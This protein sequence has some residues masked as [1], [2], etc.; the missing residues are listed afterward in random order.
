MGDVL[1]LIH[2]LMKIALV[3]VVMV[4]VATAP[5]RASATGHER[6]TSWV[7]AVMCDQDDEPSRSRRMLD[8]GDDRW[9][10]AEDASPI[11]NVDG[12]PMAGDLDIRGNFYGDCGASSMWDD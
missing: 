2:G 3:A 7:Q 12:T 5:S 4:L 1:V 11:M 8:A 9:L 10:K 6:Q